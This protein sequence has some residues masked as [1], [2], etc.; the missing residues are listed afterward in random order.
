MTEFRLLVACCKIANCFLVCLTDSNWYP[1]LS[2]LNLLASLPGYH[3][4]TP[5]R[6]FDIPHSSIEHV[7][8]KMSL[9]HSPIL[10]SPCSIVHSYYFFQIDLGALAMD[11]G[12]RG[13]GE[14]N[15]PTLFLPRPS[16]LFGLI[17]LHLHLNSALSTYRPRAYR[18]ELYQHGVWGCGGGYG[19]EG[20]KI[21]CLN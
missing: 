5:R 8:E 1:C 16:F 21:D 6:P 11:R 4:R 18:T 9:H 7:R 15:I 13:S 20:G 14:V 19:Y 3:L 2:P 12:P 17:Y 10:Y